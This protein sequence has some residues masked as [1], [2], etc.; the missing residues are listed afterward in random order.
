MTKYV[1]AADFGPS[2]KS[3]YEPNSN[4]VLKTIDLLEGKKSLRFGI[5]HAIRDLS[6]L[7]IYPSEVGLDLLVLALMVQAADTRLNR[8]QTSQNSWSRE[9]KIVV[10]VSD[11]NLWSTSDL[12]ENLR[13]MLNF[14]T[15]DFW[16]IEFVSRPEEFQK[17]IEKGTV[18]R[19]DYQ[20]V[21][22][23]SGGLDSLIGAIDLLDSKTVPLF[24]S[25]AGDAAVSGTQGDLFSKIAKHYESKKCII[26]RLRFVSARFPRDFAPNI[27]TENSTRGRSFLFFAIAAFAGTGL[28]KSFDLRVPENGLIALNV[29][30]DPTR[31]GSLSTRTT[32]PYYIH[33]WN[34]LLK[35]IGINGNVVNPYWNKTKGEMVEECKDQTLLKSVTKMSV[36]CAH[37]ASVN[38]YHGGGKIYHCGNCVPCIIRRASIERAWGKGIDDTSYKLGNFTGRKFDTLK[39]EGKQIRGFQ[40]ALSNLQ[41]HKTAAGLMI[42]KSG[43]LLEDVKILS[44][45]SGVFERGMKE[46]ESLLEGAETGPDN[47]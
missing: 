12:K 3:F 23:F 45:L 42:H 4:E 28:E 11:I 14:L 47:G 30:L 38:Q 5:R 26:N 1:L 40:Y 43:P 44:E 32:H 21:S 16:E 39:A 7:G 35:T 34:E 2:H 29:P 9:I 19:A 37:P 41:K 25:H 36:S 20:G 6:K 46:V 10:P 8:I 33:R 22:L 15:G 27:K 18:E 13:K 31:L 24:I 17:L